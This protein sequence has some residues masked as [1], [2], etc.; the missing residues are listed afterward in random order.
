MRGRKKRGRLSRKD[1]APP[2]GDSAS[3][4]PQL[5]SN[6]LS[7]EKDSESQSAIE[8][9]LDGQRPFPELPLPSLPQ[10]HSASIATTRDMEGAT[11][12]PERADI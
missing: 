1:I 12:V 7:E 3:G 11:H 10:A 5:R 6:G 9:P 8:H 2:S 4:S